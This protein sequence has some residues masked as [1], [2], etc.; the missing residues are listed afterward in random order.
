MVKSNEETIFF[1]IP[2][3]SALE[4]SSV[5]LAYAGDTGRMAFAYGT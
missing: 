1:N 4:R 2:K 3:A 5:A